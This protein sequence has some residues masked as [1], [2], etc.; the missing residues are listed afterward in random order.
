MSSLSS[1][2]SS[3][4]SLP[5]LPLSQQSNS[6]LRSR[7][8]PYDPQYTQQSLISRLISEAAEILIPPPNRNAGHWADDNRILPPG[9]PEPGPWRTSRAPY[10][11]P[12][13]DA[14][15]DP[16]VTE[17]TVV[18]G[19]QMS[20]TEGLLNIMGHRLTDG[21]FMPVLYIGPTEKQVRSMSGDRW[22]KM[23]RSTPILW[24][25]TEKGQKYRTYEQWVSGIRV[26]WGWAG[27]A[28]ELASHPAGLVLVDE[29]DRM[30]ADIG[31]EGDPVE[32]ARARTK[33]FAQGCVGVVSTPTIEGGSP[34]WALLEEGSIE[35]W[36]WRCPHCAVWFI[37]RGELLKW[38]KKATTEVAL[39]EAF[40]ACPECG[41]EIR[42]ADK[43]Q[44]NE[45]GRFIPHRKL[46]ERESNEKAIFGKYVADDHRETTSRSFWIS[47]LASPWVTFGRIAKVLVAAYHS[48]D[49]ERIQ[50]AI[51]TWLGELFRLKGDAPDWSEVA[52]LRLD[53]GRNQLP[54]G[55]Q[56][57]TVGADVQ[58]RG[59]YYV[60][61]A[62]GYHSES[63]L[64][65]EGYIEGLTEYDDV[66]LKLGRIIERKYLGHP[67]GL[68]FIDSGY[69]PGD[70]DRRPDN[71]IYSFSR[72]YPGVV[73][74]SKGHDKQ[75][76]PVKFS[77]IDYTY[78]GVAIKGGIRLYHLNT[79]YLKRWLHSR[80]RWPAG[81]PG[82]WHLHREA[83]EDYCKQIVSEELV[84]KPSGAFVWI[85][86]RADNH[87]LDCEVNALAAAIVAGVETLNAPKKPDDSSTSIEQDEV[88]GQ[89]ERR[90]LF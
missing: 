39:R 28:T 29:R 52:K 84:V 65:D 89:Y 76:R 87:Y 58:K 3:R 63:W 53:Y 69:R 42:S 61:R 24:N 35:F 45:G 22:S 33:N 5:G 26:G 48:G 1:R 68:A 27:S 15:A 80:V 36:A 77:L 57:V 37:P 8:A 46:D 85:K 75:D 62:W 32:L 25:R 9:S 86:R 4:A 30:S 17:I 55:A 34:V 7:L 19:A 47:G 12:I 13:Y 11:W 66:Y 72:R 60:V 90:G 67:V 71:A 16:V 59:I 10:W 54:P 20:K 18:C 2:A 49:P 88:G 43:Q 14:F 82:G 6:V 56:L 81:D 50:A 83:T 23:I 21:P 74:P 40:V 70:T 79:D 78:G 44:L 31:G 38:P 41:G 64:I 73:Y 51:N